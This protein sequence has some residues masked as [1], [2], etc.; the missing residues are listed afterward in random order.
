MDHTFTT[1]RD[2]QQDIMTN[3][4]QS[5]KCNRNVFSANE[6]SRKNITYQIFNTTNII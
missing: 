2:I 1:D 5:G 4:R 3:Y 6:I